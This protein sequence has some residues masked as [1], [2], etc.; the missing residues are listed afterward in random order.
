VEERQNSDGRRIDS[1]GDR[2]RP[3]EAADGRDA[4][5]LR[6]LQVIYTLSEALGRAAAVA[7]VSEAALEGLLEAVDADRASVLLFDDAGVMRFSAWRGLSDRYRNAVEGHSPWTRDEADPR[8][9]TIP[10][11]ATCGELEPELRET[12]LG[13]GLRAL[14]FIPLASGGRLLGKF[15]VYYDR[16][17]EFD[18]TELQ[19]CETVARH[20]AWAIERS[21]A[22]HAMSESEARFRLM[23]DAAPVMIWISGTDRR[24]TWFNTPWLRFTGRS[25][26]EEIGDGWVDH[27]HPDDVE[28]CLTTYVTAFD[29]R[30]PFSMEY[31]LRRHD[32][33]YR[34]HLD[35]A[36]PLYGG[37]GT[38]AG[39]IGSCV[40]ITERRRA[41][42][43]LRR[44][45]ER[46]RAVVESQAEMLC[47]FRRDGTILFVNGAYARARGTSPEALIGR[48]LW[49]FVSDD[50]R[51]SVARM[52]DELSP[53]A[54]ETAIEN[55]FETVDGARWTLWTNRGLSFD[56]E[57]RVVE[58]QAS[59]I[60]ITDRKRA[61]R[62]LRDSEERFRLATEAGG[63]G[64]WDWNVV[65]G[66]V[67]W[68]DALYAIHGVEPGSFRGTV[69]AFTDLIHPDDRAEVEAA[70]HRALDGDAEYELEFRIRRPDADTTWIYTQATVI[71]S[72]TG[73]PIRMLGATVDITERKRAEEALR[74]N[75]RRK[76]E[77]LATLSHELRNPLAPLVTMLEVMKS[78]TLDASAHARA[79]GMMERQLG[80][81]VRLV[82]DLLDVSRISRGKIELRP[83]RIELGAVVR[84]A[85]EDF[86]PLA[87][88]EEQRLDLR[89]PTEPI[90]LSA[91]AVRL[92]QVV[93]NLLSNASKFTE[94]GG[95]ISV[96]LER[97][98]ER[99]VIRV[100]DTGI[101]IEP[102]RLP[103]V[104]DMF[105][106]TEGLS[107]RA[108]S[109]LGIGLA[110]AK[111]LVELHG[112][113]V[114]AHSEGPGTGSE[115]VVDLPIAAA[116]PERRVTPVARGESDG[117]PRRILVV[118]DNRDAA[119]TLSLLLV[120]AGHE[121]YTA[122]DG[123]QALEA[124]ARLRP[125]VILLDIGLPG[126]DGY[127]V[128]RRVR[129]E[130]G[131]HVVLI[132]LTGW[133]QEAD[134]RRSRDAGFDAHMVKPPDT[135]ELHRLIAAS[136]VS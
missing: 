17:H 40:D 29:A 7:E 52:L 97:K 91:D 67:T 96:S 112:G 28:R 25:M 87:R 24:C 3:R 102:S 46:Y 59:G 41:E 73:A 109:G 69:D 15:M 105:S 98:G 64:I 88:R 32:G 130:R 20:V 39:F 124:A 117:G 10:D 76:D 119:E 92:T 4:P 34:W 122:F 90:F 51:E 1:R 95:S 123:R 93:G 42:E 13:E 108:N 12:I 27:V 113:T 14:G 2:G 72:D 6:H 49:E 45:E 94:R 9:I 19:L 132:A 75:D 57:G 5:G 78:E 84:G 100:R 133:G 135:E 80:H 120:P 58:A 103:R 37:D 31:R 63:V 127:E 33:V 129:D 48:D 79:L 23:A 68:S 47:R 55:R 131:E 66:A 74:E 38:F 114:S 70:I 18:D 110:L 81:M 86:S 82:D 21:Q 44:S 104:F 61:E 53:E 77:F 85:V 106:Q 89:L 54:P 125:D 134:R 116:E 16:P 136:A 71:R 83:E 121:V 26:E 8:P 11:V 30:E 118:D 101:G 62:A 35:H 43:S 56:A 22:E 60:D 111:S 65:T 107:G 128:A 115:F 36:T 50:D 126:L 99:A